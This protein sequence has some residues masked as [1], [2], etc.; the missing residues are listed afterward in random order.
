MCVT[1]NMK[2]KIMQKRYFKDGRSITVNEN[3]TKSKNT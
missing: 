1:V 2:V 3:V